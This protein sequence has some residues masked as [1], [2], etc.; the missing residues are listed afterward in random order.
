MWRNPSPTGLIHVRDR[1]RGAV[2]L[3]FDICVTDPDGGV[4]VELDG[5][6]MRRLPGPSDRA[7]KRYETVLRAAPHLGLPAAPSPLPGR[8]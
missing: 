5:V 3:C 4:T 6:R 1:T 8:L 2:E 7:P